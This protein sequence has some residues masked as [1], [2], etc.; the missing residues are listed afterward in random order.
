MGHAGM[1]CDELDDFG[2][3]LQRLDRTEGQS[4]ETGKF[5]RA[6]DQFVEARLRMKVAAVCAQMDPRKDD[7][8]I[9]ARDQAADFIQRSLR[10]DASAAASHRR[11]DAEGAIRVAAVL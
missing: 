4:L 8:F 7:L 5:Q 3:D 2:N 1:G 9:A 10:I 6:A 11:N